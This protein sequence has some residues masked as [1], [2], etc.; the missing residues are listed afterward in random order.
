MEKFQANRPVAI[1]GLGIMGTKVAWACARAGL[2]TH[3]FD[4]D[5]S[6]AA[7]SQKNALSWSDE[8]ERSVV[9]SHLK[10]CASLTEA[11]AGVQLAFENVPEKLALKQ[12]VHQQ[13]QEHLPADAYLGSNTSS[14]L[15]SPLAEASGRADRFFCLNFN[16]PRYSKL[17]EL[18]GCELTAEA[19]LSFAKDWARAIGMVPVQTHKEQMGYSGNRLWRVIKQEV[20]RQIEG[21]Y[22]T[23]EDIDR[24]WM[25]NWGVD[26]GP[27][28]LMDDVGLH[29]ILSVENSY[30]AAS[31]DERDKPPQ[32][33]VDMVER[34]DTGT[35]AGK[36]FYDYPNPA[37]RQPDFLS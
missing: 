16:D 17:V 4:A 5:T 21:G 3:I 15:C 29:T 14:L 10:I 8:P 9:T 22:S 7:H 35:E 28:G 32:Y 26:M 11:L 2:T 20:L 24:G 12:K 25:L 27:C 23:P 30:Y 19:T 36:G 31:G 18:M 37:F 34:G 6:Q 13:L 1:I 33:L